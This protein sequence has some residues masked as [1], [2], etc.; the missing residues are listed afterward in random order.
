MWLA[1]PVSQNSKGRIPNLL[2]V[3]S[4]GD[5]LSLI[6]ISYYHTTVDDYANR[7]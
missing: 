1:L 5:C 6:N 2:S 3:Y 4:D 7:S